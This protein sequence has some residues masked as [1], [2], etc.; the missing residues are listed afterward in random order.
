VKKYC[1]LL[2]L[3]FLL[4]LAHI[5]ALKIIFTESKLSTKESE[6]PIEKSK[7][8]LLRRKMPNVSWEK[9][10]NGTR[11]IRSN[12]GIAW[13]GLSDVT[14]LDVGSNVNQAKNDFNKAVPFAGLQFGMQWNAFAAGDGAGL[15][16]LVLGI[17]YAK[18]KEVVTMDFYDTGEASPSFIIKQNVN[19]FR[20]IPKAEYEFYHTRNCSLGLMGGL[21]VS[22]K[23]LDK[24]KVFEKDTGYYIGKRLEPNKINILGQVGFGLTYV[25]KK[26]WAG[27]VHYHYTRGKVTYK[28]TLI[29]ETPHVN[30]A[31]HHQDALNITD[32]EL[33]LAEKPTM[34]LH[35]H[36]IGWSMI[37]EF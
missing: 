22:V 9:F 5:Q 1:S 8:A 30:A 7:P 29:I 18:R 11:S 6:M 21:V 14:V 35:C 17:N 28:K 20:I 36:E 3:G 26:N 37:Y 12:G 13:Y 10:K 32:T 34:K 31:Q 16:H 19:D 23:T 24:L 2:I 15:F 4:P 25:M 27:R 33:N